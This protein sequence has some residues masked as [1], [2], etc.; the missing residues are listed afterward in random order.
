MTLRPL[1]AVLLTAALAASIASAARAAGAP[2][3]KVGAPAPALPASDLDGARLE[4]AGLR[5][6]VVV[7]DFFATWCV[8]CRAQ[9]PKFVALQEKHAAKGLVVIGVSLDDD[10]AKVREFRKKLG[11]TYRVAMGDAKLAERWGGILGLPVAFV[12]DRDG[13]VRA[14]QEGEGDLAEIERDAERLLKR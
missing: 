3:P 1:G 5:G 7:V 11:M 12:V 9:V 13:D 6:K 8:P 10:A 14:R 4:W 2:V